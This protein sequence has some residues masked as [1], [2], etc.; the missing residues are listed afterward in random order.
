MFVLLEGNVK[1]ERN[2]EQVNTLGPGDFLGEGALMLGKPRN[3]TITA[4]SPLRALVITEGNFK[5]LLGED[6]DRT[7]GARDARRENAA[8]RVRLDSQRAAA[9]RTRRSSSCQAFRFL[10]LLEEGTAT[11]RDASPTRST[12]APARR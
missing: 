8:R 6:P 3:A 4:T 9:S 10:R 2:G 11:D 12:S 7:N 5:Q 1:V